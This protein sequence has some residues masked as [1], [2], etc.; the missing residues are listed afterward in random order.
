MP[1]LQLSLDILALLFMTGLI[2]GLVDAIAGGGGLIA[3]PVL[4]ATGLPPIQALATNKLQGSFGTFSSSLYFI[5]NGLICLREIR[6]MVG[7][8]FIGSA[9]GTLIVQNISTD[10]LASI[11]PLLLIGI[12]LY[13]LLSPRISDEQ[14]PARISTLLFSLSIGFG[15]GFYD[16]FF[17]PGAG[18]FFAIGFVGLLGFGLTK[19]TAHTKILNLTSNLASLCFFALSGYVIWSI[20][21][22]M[23]LGQLIGARIGARLVLRRG[24]KLIRPMIVIISI[25]ISIKLFLG[26]NPDLLKW[27]GLDS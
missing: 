4:L 11:I 20:G 25:L 27:I 2:A 26:N 15:I 1:D 10:S 21:L 5:R 14:Q 16:G 13:F 19:A 18:S 22:T 24:V 17:G 7:C 3:L 23:G 9:S 8:T 12:A 6:F